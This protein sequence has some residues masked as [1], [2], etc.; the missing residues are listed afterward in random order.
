MLVTK[1]ILKFN[2]F[3]FKKFLTIQ[4]DC[5]IFLKIDGDTK[6]LKKNKLFKFSVIMYYYR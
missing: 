6:Y 2:K 1:D 5:G 3:M 4:K